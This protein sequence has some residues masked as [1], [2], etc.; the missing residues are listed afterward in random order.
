MT[1][2]IPTKVTIGS[3]A[4]HF[5]LDDGVSNGSSVS[6]TFDIPEPSVTTRHDL[7]GWILAEKEKL[8]LFVLSAEVLKGALSKEDF[9]RRR[10]TIKANYDR[11]LHRLSEDDLPIASE[12]DE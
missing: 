2:L 6:M 5:N 9:A 8:D 3:E 1:K 7:N 12:T 10:A 11:V 4:K